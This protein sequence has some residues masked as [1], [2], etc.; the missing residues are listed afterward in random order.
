MIAFPKNRYNQK[1]GKAVKQFLS[2]VDKKSLVFI[3]L[4]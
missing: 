1:S 4:T 3:F 2:P